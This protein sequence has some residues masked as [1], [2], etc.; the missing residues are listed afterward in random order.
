[1]RDTLP[2]TPRK[3]ESAIVNMDSSTGAGTHWVCYKKLGDKVRYFDSF[4]DLRPP[5]ELLRYLG[6]AAADI[7][8]NY[9]RRQSVDSVICGHLCL[10]FL[11]S[12]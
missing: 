12:R 11:C 5:W 4:G 8:Y 2:R 7:Q 9:E 10:K 6:S 1:M 3:Y